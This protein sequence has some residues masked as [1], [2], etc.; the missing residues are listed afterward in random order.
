MKLMNRHQHIRGQSSL[1]QSR[2]NLQL[3]L[4][5]S[6]QHLQINHSYTNAPV[7]E[8][9]NGYD[10]KRPWQFGPSGGKGL[11]AQLP[12]DHYYNQ[13]KIKN[14]STK[15]NYMQTDKKLYKCFKNDQ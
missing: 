9:Q 1:Q 3:T 14:F 2:P 15:D 10:Q 12:P 8:Q 11:Q 13:S 4:R 6:R 5:I 7:S